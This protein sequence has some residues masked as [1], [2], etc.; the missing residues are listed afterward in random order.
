MALVFSQTLG[1]QKN[2]EGFSTADKN[3]K[4]TLQGSLNVSLYNLCTNNGLKCK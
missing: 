1:L 2:N 4:N 3:D